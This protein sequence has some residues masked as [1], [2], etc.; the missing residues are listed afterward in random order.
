[1]GACS[2]RLV[3]CS[4]STR[5]CGYA[6]DVDMH[7][8]IQYLWDETSR[9]SSTNAAF[10]ESRRAATAPHVSSTQVCTRRMNL[11]AGWHA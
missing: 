5:A 4:Q 10:A 3:D 1:M 6:G 9:N 11:L 8:F 7:Y 2:L